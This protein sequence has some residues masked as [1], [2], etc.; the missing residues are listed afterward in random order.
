METLRF[1]ARYSRSGL[2]AKNPLPGTERNLRFLYPS[3]LYTA[4]LFSSGLSLCS[5][6]VERII[7]ERNRAIGIRYQRLYSPAF[8]C[9]KANGAYGAM[10]TALRLMQAF[11]AIRWSLYWRCLQ[12][13]KGSTEFSKIILACE[14]TDIRRGVDGL[15][16]IV[17]L[18]YDLDTTEAGTLS[19]LWQ[20]A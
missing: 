1:S 16:A 11:P 17:R 18:H 6:T 15:A 10:D 7:R 20:K 19:F 12:M 9:R 13:L 4:K 5:T 2:S 14:F 3:A 8:F